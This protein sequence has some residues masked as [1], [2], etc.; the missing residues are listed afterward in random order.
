MI[1]DE[2]VNVTERKTNNSL[3]SLEKKLD[4]LSTQDII[5]NKFILKPSIG[6]IDYSNSILKTNFVDFGSKTKEFIKELESDQSLKD[7]LS[8]ENPLAQEGKTFIKLNL[9]LGI[10]EKKEDKPV[11]ENVIMNN[12]LDDKKGLLD[13]EALNVN[14]CIEEQEILKFLLEGGE[15]EVKKK[16]LKRRR[17]RAEYTK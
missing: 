8:I 10:L 5:L 14:S 4:A 15:E 1:A 16:K 12:I 13:P 6:K 11:D 7:K 17:K 9:G 3:L 2:N